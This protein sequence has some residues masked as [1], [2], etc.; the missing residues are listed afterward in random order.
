ML[1]L[2]LLFIL[3]FLMHISLFGHDIAQSTKVEKPEAHWKDKVHFK[4]QYA[5]GIGF[6]SP[7][8]GISHS[9]Q[10][11]ETDVFLG[12]APKW[13]AGDDIVMLT[14][15]NTFFPLKKEL[16]QLD[17]TIHPIS[18]GIFLNY[19]F[20][21]QFSNFWTDK[22]P[23]GYYWWDSSIRWGLFIGGKLSKP[24]E[25]SNI[26]KISAYYEMG[27]NDL[28]F[29]SYVRNTGY[30]GLYDILNLALGLKFKF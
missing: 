23:K 11:I 27:F 18:A 3:T 8:I 16:P 7:G 5:G 19:T 28:Y 2:G 13:L 15:K 29:V 14:F 6:I 21:S 9:Q 24:L 10:K 22:Y 1:R 20:G 17:L 12:Y 26:K 4:L 30:L 25:N